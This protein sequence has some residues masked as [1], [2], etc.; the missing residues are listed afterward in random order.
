MQGNQVL[1]ES[2]ASKVCEVKLAQWEELDREDQLAL[3]V[4]LVA[5]EKMALRDPRVFRAL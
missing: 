3:R 5:L 1:R 2:Q 4:H